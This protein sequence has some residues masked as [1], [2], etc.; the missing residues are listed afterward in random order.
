VAATWDPDL[1]RTMREIGRAVHEE[2][3]L[4]LLLADLAESTWPPRAGG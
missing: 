2:E 4:D 3:V 1:E